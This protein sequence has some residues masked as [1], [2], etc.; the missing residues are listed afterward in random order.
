MISAKRRDLILS[1][2][3]GGN[4]IFAHWSGSRGNMQRG[5]TTA[6]GRSRSHFSWT[7]YLFNKERS[8]AGPEPH[9]P[10]CYGEEK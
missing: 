10:G 7:P 4:W 1:A 8:C 9:I 3:K 5:D 2:L 6:D